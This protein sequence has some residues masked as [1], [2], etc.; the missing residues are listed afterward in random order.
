MTKDRM[1]KKLL[2]CVILATLSQ[3]RAYAMHN[4]SET[5][6]ASFSNQNSCMAWL[7]KSCAKCFGLTNQDNSK[8]SLWTSPTG[9]SFRQVVESFQ[10]SVENPGDQKTASTK[11]QTE[12]LLHN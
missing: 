10:F 12:S 1:I 8:E 6:S 11:D 5:S 7:R 9:N 4:P 2:L 3:M